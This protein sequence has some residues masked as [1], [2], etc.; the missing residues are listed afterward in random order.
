MTTQDTDTR[1][2]A[3]TDD[4]L[5]DLDATG[6]AERIRSREISAAEAVEAAIE[7]SRRV[8]ESLQALQHPDFD[9]AR[10]R[11][12]DPGSAEFAGVPAAF[13]DNIKVGGMPMT[14]GSQALPR[15][16]QRKD[17]RIAAQF[18]QTGIIPIGTTTMPE[19]GW[20]ATTETLSRQTQNPWHLD[21]SSGGSSGGSAA[22]VAS[23]VVPIAHGND[24]GG[25]IRIPAAV[26]GLVGLKP[27]RGRLRLTDGGEAMPVRIVTDS[28]LARSVR[29]VANF[30][31]AA[32]RVHR[33]R[34][35]PPI[36]GVDR[37]ID[38]PLRIGLLLDSPVAPPTDAASRASVEA[39]GRLLETLGHRVEPYTL[40]VPDFFKSDFIDY[41]RFLALAVESSGARMFGAGFDRDKLEPLT[42]GL[43]A[44]G[45]SRL[46]KAPV[47][48]SRL[49][50]S[51][52][53]SRMAFAKGPDVVLSPVLAHATPKLGYF[54]ADL[55]AE[56]H[57]RRLVDYTGFTPLHNATGGPAISV[58]S[59]R[60][61]EGL[62]IG[63]MLS[64]NH[65]T[66][67][68]LLRLAL[69][70]EQAQPWKRIQD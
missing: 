7:R 8:E 61:A 16:P 53:A 48:I 30:Y 46:W 59:G 15:T 36:E 41:W 1:V 33:N 3:F 60:T 31:L 29:D 57:F 49:L 4:A 69:Q 54:S 20:T 66:E 43:A 26:C 28:V 21:Y 58:P 67:S 47:F 17:G 63:A 37:P 18:R 27:T 44:Q 32:Q 9:R 14:E 6:V 40:P 25:S 51:S 23:G 42:R 52:A 35:L 65:G 22:W 34:L 10:E 68:L 55:S 5:G 39:L 50:A 12:Q 13:K 24:G 2:H 19:F 45:R 70:I 64:A 56:E 62:P 38:R 11:A